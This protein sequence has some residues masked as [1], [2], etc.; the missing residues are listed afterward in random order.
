MKTLWRLHGIQWKLHGT[1][2][3]RG[4]W[5]PMKLCGE[6]VGSLMLRSAR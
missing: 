4:A 6:T 1:M 2:E 5:N 3:L